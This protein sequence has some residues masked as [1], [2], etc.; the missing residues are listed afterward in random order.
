MPFALPFYIQLQF[1]P[2]SLYFVFPGSK[3]ACCSVI[4]LFNFQTLQNLWHIKTFGVFFHHASHAENRSAGSNSFLHES[5]PGMR[6]TI[7]ASIIIC[8]NDLFLDY[9]I[10]RE[11]VSLILHIWVVIFTF[12][13]NRPAIFAIETLSP[14]TI[15]NTTIWL[16]IERSFLATGTTCLMGANR[17]I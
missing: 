8:W 14:P 17:I 4:V 5:N 6:N 9:R 15:E 12:L 2:G 7:I 13:A 11:T 1:R 3:G 16:T 10:Q